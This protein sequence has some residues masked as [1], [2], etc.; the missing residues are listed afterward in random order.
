[1]TSNN[2]LLCWLSAPYRLN[3]SV[4]DIW[5]KFRSLRSEMI[6]KA[7]LSSAGL[8]H[9]HPGGQR[10]AEVHLGQVEPPPQ[11]QPARHSQWHGH[12]RVGPSH[13]EVSSGTALKRQYSSFPLNP[14]HFCK[15]WHWY[16]KWALFKGKA[17][18]FF[19][20]FYKDLSSCF[21]VLI[22]F[23]VRILELIKPHVLNNIANNK[24]VPGRRV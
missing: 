19:I 22:V 1:M 16:F 2:A 14:S 10:S 9:R 15:S 8:Q 20:S 12:T 24:P 11:L 6:M 3:L 4:T 17:G 7:F 21:S 18:C 13:H 5:M 23:T